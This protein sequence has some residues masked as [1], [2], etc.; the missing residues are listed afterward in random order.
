MKRLTCL[1][2]FCLVALTPAF[3]ADLKI[4]VVDLQRAIS[5]SKAGQDS[6]KQ[7]ETE[8]RKFQKRVAEMY[9][10]VENLKKQLNNTM[11]TLNSDALDAKMKEL[12]WKDRDVR[13]FESDGEEEIL[14]LRNRVRNQL[15]QSFVALAQD[16]AKKDS[17]DF[18]LERGSLIHASTSYDFTDK[19]VKA[20]DAEYAKQK[21]AK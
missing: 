16:I 19:L 3:A 12:K 17:Y 4:G 8:V 11:G 10:E 18:V 7:L 2:L 15:A 21:K 9:E 6:E 5:E 1:V 13:R 20:A 14:E